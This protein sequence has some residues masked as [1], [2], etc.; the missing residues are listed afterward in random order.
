MSVRV[1]ERS[2]SK[3][4]VQVRAEELVSHTVHIMSNPKVFDP[5]YSRF[6][7][8][9]VDCAVSVGESLWEANGIR[10]D[11][12]PERYRLRRAL[13][14]RA[15]R[16]INNMFYLMAVARRLDHLRKRK[17]SHWVEM[18]RSVKELAVAWRDSDARRYGHLV[19]GT[20]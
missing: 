1:S 4:E 8:R 20:G 2:E 18:T 5:K 16:S 13:Q 11:K 17:Y 7:D 9:I 3:L 6:H 10:V 14:D 15:I 19:Q 12:D